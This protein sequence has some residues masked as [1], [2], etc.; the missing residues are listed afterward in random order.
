MGVKLQRSSVDHGGSWRKL[1]YLRR[2]DRMGKRSRKDNFWVWRAD[3]GA[4]VGWYINTTKN[5]IIVNGDY[6]TLY[7][8]MVEHFH[9][10]QTVWNGEHGRTYFYQSEIP[11][12]VPNQVSWMSHNGTKNGFAFYKV[13]DHVN[14][15]ET[16]GMG[17]YS[18]FRDA[19]VKLHSAVESPIK[20]GVRHHNTSEFEVLEYVPGDQRPTYHIPELPTP[21]VVQ[22]GKGSYAVNDIKLAQPRQPKYVTQNVS[23]PIPSNDWWTSVSYK[24]LSDGIVAL[25]LRFEYF[26]TGLGMFYA[27]PI[28]TAPNNGG[29]DTKLSNMD[30]F[31]NTGSIV[32]TPEARVDGFGDW[33]VDVVFSDDGTPKMRNTIIKGSPYVY[34]T[35]TDPNSVE[36]SSPAIVGLFDDNRCE[37][38]LGNSGRQEL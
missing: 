35:F 33:S 28:F 2:E 20:Q 12:D 3:H 6:V 26:D 21:G 17:I 30:L 9:E 23:V 31:I 25:P 32:R 18:Y 38:E 13:A 19:P 29:M 36:I 27:S 1:Q 11:Y 22:V 24:R 14:Y 37:A 10:Y 16:W 15:H 8:L 34:S 5:G 4:G 7:A